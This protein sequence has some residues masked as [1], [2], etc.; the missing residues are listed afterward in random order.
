MEP[1]L[2]KSPHS[3]AVMNGTIATESVEVIEEHT[4]AI[5]FIGALCIP[6]SK[7]KRLLQSCP[8]EDTELQYR[9]SETTNC[10]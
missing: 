6:V 7:E 3:E 8:A 10:I 2:Q 9:V 1:L 5:S 4:E